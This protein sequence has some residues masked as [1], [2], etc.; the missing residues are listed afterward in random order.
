[1]WLVVGQHGKDRLLAAGRSANEAW[2]VASEQ[3]KAA[4]KRGR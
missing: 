1:V 3:A 4:G 2:W